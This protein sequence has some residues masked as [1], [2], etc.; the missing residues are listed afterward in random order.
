[1]KN[2]GKVSENKENVKNDIKKQGGNNPITVQIEN[3]TILN[4][5]ADLFA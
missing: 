3:N 2:I 1:M 5:N 4:T